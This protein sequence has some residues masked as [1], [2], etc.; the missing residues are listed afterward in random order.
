MSVEKI[1]NYH[2][3]TVVL[4]HHVTCSDKTDGC[5][6]CVIGMVRDL[7][8]AYEAKQL[9]SYQS[10]INILASNDSMVDWA[11]QIKCLRG[12]FTLLHSVS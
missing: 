10:Y 11:F 9:L 2:I 1:N 4:Q 5:V 7:L 8:G 3:K 12:I 6:E